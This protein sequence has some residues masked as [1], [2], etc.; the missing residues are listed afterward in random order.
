MRLEEV[1]PVVV[2]GAKAFD[3]GIEG[4]Q[5]GGQL[6]TGVV[7]I[8]TAIDVIALPDKLCQPAWVW[9]GS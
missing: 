5:G 6:V 8:E 4:N 2:L 7:D 9:P 1:I 3:A